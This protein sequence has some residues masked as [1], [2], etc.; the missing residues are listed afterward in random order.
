MD[1]I[2]QSAQAPSCFKNVRWSPDGT[3]ALT[4]LD[5]GSIDLY[6]LRHE[7][8]G[9]AEMPRLR[10]D[11][12]CRRREPEVV[13]DYLWNPLMTSQDPATCF[14]CTTAR[15]QPVHIWDAFSGQLRSSIGAYDNGDDLYAC[16]SIGIT[17][18]GATLYGGV[19]NGVFVFD[20]ERGSRDRRRWTVKDPDGGDF[21]GLVS[22]MAFDR[23]SGHGDIVALGSYSGMVGVFDEK[24]S[25]HLLTMPSHRRGVTSV[26]FSP[27]GTVPSSS[28]PYRGRLIA[29]CTLQGCTYGPAGAA[30][31]TCSAGM[32]G[33]RRSRCTACPASWATTSAS[34]ST[35]NAPGGM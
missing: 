4:A 27:C 12:V 13:Y 25:S 5:D 22:C 9:A 18:D 16:L 3:C 32:F 24:S 31:P 11:H 29:I 14:F 28:A 30:S 8:Q 34:T 15:D 19:S 10:L 6:E 21:Y 35:W 26:K 17:P 7:D 1:L 20:L 2:W 23:A 33:T